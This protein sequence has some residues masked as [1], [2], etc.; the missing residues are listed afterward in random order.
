MSEEQ[1]T[2][3][4]D[5][6]THLLLLVVG[7]HLRA[8]EADRPLA[9]QLR[10]HIR[11]WLKE[12]ADVLNESI[13]PVVCSDIWYLNNER[14]QRRPTVCIGGPGV[15]ALSAFFAQHLPQESNFDRQVVIQIDPDFTDL[16]V[17]LWGSDNELTKKGL[18]V[19]VNQ[20]LDGY[21]RAVATQVE[22]KED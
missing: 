16:R 10:E 8:E 18:D 6:H 7:S 14:L 21:L 2:S 12:H 5:E 1:E 22:P 4:G 11:H 9:Y 3:L 19:F 20:Y 15:N 17:C 13:E